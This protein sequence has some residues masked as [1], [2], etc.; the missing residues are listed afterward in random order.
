MSKPKSKDE[1]PTSGGVP[2][3]DKASEAEARLRAY[4][5]LGITVRDRVKEGRLDADTILK[6]S[7]ETGHAADNIRKAR[8]FADKYTAEQLDE[9]CKLRTPEGMPLPWRHVRQLLMLP[10]GESRDAFQRK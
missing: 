7:E 9:L 4:H 8:V 10:P 3:R 2:R 5:A 6:L 1:K